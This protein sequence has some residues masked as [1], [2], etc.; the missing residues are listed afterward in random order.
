MAAAKHI[1]PEATGGF[2]KEILF[3]LMPEAGGFDTGIRGLRMARWDRPTEVQRCFYIPMIIVI[4]QGNK[5]VYI[6]SQEFTYGENQC[7]ITG[8]ELPIAGRIT[9]ASP[10]KP[11][12]TIFL[13]LDQSVIVDLLAEIPPSKKEAKIENA[14]HRGMTVTD[15]D[16]SVLD[17]FLRLAELIDDT[18]RQGILAPMIIR[19]IHYRLLTGPLG[20][21]LRMIHTQGSHSN[22]IARA[23]AWLKAHYKQQVTIENLAKMVN[24]APATFN[25]Y[26]R[27]LTTI[28]PLQYQ[29][30][31]RLYEA[32]RLMLVENQN[33]GNAAYLVG[34]ES[35]TQFNREYKRMFGEP[36]LENKK[37]ILSG[38]L[39]PYHNE[40]SV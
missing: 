36:P 16:P 37:R 25:R 28:S 26:F 34:Y 30:R 21:Q 29:K 38:D 1:N 33:A 15:T 18:E 23:I 22:Q 13:E 9:R 19:E 7:M 17:A 11:S 4:V 5:Q 27:Q 31:L 40:S 12:M 39:R 14:V 8:L 35:P 2:L 10:N 6:G 20:H 32:Q 24:M 3:S